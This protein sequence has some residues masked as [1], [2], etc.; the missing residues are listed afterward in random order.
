M[1]G[2]TEMKAGTLSSLWVAGC[3]YKMEIIKRE[4]ENFND[5]NK[6]GNGEGWYWMKQNREQYQGRVFRET[7]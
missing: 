3:R 5:E 7:K 1:L 4:R 6:N 2:G